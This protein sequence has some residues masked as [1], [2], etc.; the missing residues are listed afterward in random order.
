MPLA[1]AVRLSLKQS[2]IM[3]HW[4]CQCELEKRFNLD[5]ALTLK[6]DHSQGQNWGIIGGG[7][8]GMTLAWRLSGRGQ[9]VT[10]LEG[11]AGFGGL[12]S[13]WR[14]GDVTWDRFYHVVL[15][16]D[17]DLRDLLRELDLESEMKWVETRTGFYSDGRLHSMSNTVEFLRFPPLNSWQKFRLG[18]TIFYG[19]KVTNWRRLEKIPVERW[20][21]RLSG[22]TTFNKIWLPL[23][24]AKLG[25]TYKETSAAFIWSYI[26]RM[27][28]AR[29]TGMKREMFGYVPG[30]YASVLERFCNR[31]ESADVELCPDHAVQEVR[32]DPARR[33]LRVRFSG[34]R[35]RWF[36]RVILTVP[37]SI[38]SRV[39][40]DL[41]AEEHARF[42]NVRYMG[43]ICASLLLRRPLA[44]YYVTNI[45]DS[46]IPLT[47]VIEM[48]AIVNPSE[49]GGHSLVYLPKY[50]ASTDDGA[51][52]ESDGTIR[53]RMLSTLEKMYPDFRRADVADFKIARARCVMALPTIGYSEQ[54]PPVR[55]S[56]PGLF[57]INSAQIVKG[58]LNVNETIQIGDEC[59]EKYVYPELTSRAE[60]IPPKVASLS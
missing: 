32:Y 41:S 57:A 51:F 3:C 9:R 43:V 23:L 24:R 58:N 49:L 15:L 19:S 12:A 20:L 48:S 30:G 17:T 36:D 26:A 50:V 53:E 14:L 5:R 54:L 55:T 29:R 31:L 59:L 46:D 45:T 1:L 21:R 11:G 37:S 2:S 25:E 34:D 38:I 44:G 16:S 35:E 6:M 18:G 10:L 60:A 42:R 4:L 7:M 47:G 22:G 39:C 56:I 27:Y 40:P 33:Q 8:L 13:A 28:K 52:A